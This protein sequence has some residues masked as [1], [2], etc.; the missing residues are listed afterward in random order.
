MTDAKQTPRAWF[1]KQTP[2]AREHIPFAKTVSES[3][4]GSG[5]E[6]KVTHYPPQD[7]GGA[8]RCNVLSFRGARSANDHV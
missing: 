1:E 2:R 5:E 3:L 8:L 6:H 4:V 7:S